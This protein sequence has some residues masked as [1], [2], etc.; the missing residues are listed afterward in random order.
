MVS[1]IDSVG[2]FLFF[3]FLVLLWL[4]FAYVQSVR[5]GPVG[6]F[7]LGFFLLRGIVA[8]LNFKLGILPLQ[9]DALHYHITAQKAAD[10]IS[11]GNFVGLL[12]D[13][14]WIEPAYVILLG[15]AYYIFGKTYLVGLIL[16]TFIF[17]WTSYRVYGIG[18]LCFG[19]AAGVAALLLFSILPYSMLHSTYLYRDPI[20]NYFLCEFFYRLLRM[21]QCEDRTLGD[22]AAITFAFIYSGLLRRENLV[23]LCAI[24]GVLW[25]KGV[26][27]RRSM[28]MPV[29]V[30]VFVMVV[31]GFLVVVSTSD[32]WIFKNF[33]S[34]V[35]VEALSA[36][37]VGLQEA[38]SAYLA[39]MKYDSYFDVVVQAP[40][41]A[42]YFMFVPFPWMIM[43]L[44]HY[45]SFMEVMIIF[46]LVCILP[47]ALFVLAKKKRSAFIYAASIFLF[48]GITG[49]GLIQS[50]VAGAQR[51]RTQFTFLIVAISVSYL[52][53]CLEKRIP[54]LRNGLRLSV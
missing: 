53:S 5:L 18:K 8:I 21:S 14:C 25:A 15:F 26:F 2:A 41:R 45:I 3:Y 30:V 37:V 7:L 20:I 42:L 49:S 13:D 10:Y 11:R 35:K 28:F 17:S 40:I 33:T 47:R 44:S 46:P 9:Q 51:H 48:V 52:Y 31:S 54:F 12:S 32:A 1:I 29:L 36:R 38:E 34:L 39:D 6:Y 22:W 24:L 16:N 50:N 23:I 43:K 4:C 27:T 19:E